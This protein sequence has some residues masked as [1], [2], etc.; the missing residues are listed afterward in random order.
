MQTFLPYKNFSLSA[1][2]LDYKRLGK[3]RV[4]AFQVLNVLLG[5]TKTKAKGWLNHPITKMWT[6]YENALK[7]YTNVM[8]DEWINR[9]YNNTMKH[10][11]I[12]GN[13]VYPSWLGNDLFHS[14][15]RANLL[16]KD[17]GYYSKF[18][19]NEDSS[20]PYAWY[21]IHKKQ[22]YLQ[23]VKEKMRKYIQ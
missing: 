18:Y 20:S 7:L 4:E 22:W 23:M 11:V 14:S 12:E 9:G 21:D 5:R 15:H 13:I 19:W 16:R 8:I 10:E 1:Q 17:E 6:N 2:T 3:Q